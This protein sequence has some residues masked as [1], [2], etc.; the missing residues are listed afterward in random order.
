MKKHNQLEAILNDKF[1][2]YY[3]K[4]K[5]DNVLY[6]HFDFAQQLNSINDHLKAIVDQPLSSQKHFEYDIKKKNV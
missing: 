4:I 5:M 2:Y 3:G 1:S 6:I